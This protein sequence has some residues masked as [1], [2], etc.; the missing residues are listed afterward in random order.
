MIALIVAAKPRADLTARFRFKCLY[1]NLTIASSNLP[2]N[3]L[4]SIV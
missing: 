4:Y 3:R 1:F 2:V